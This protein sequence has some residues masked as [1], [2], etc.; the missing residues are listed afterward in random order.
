MTRYLIG[1]VLLILLGYGYMEALPLL[2][3]PTLA[4]ASPANNASFPGGIVDIQGV[5]GRA[6]LL[7]LD[8]MPLL[9]DQN[10]EFSSTLTFPSGGSILTFTV[11]DRFGRTVRVTR[12]IFVPTSNQSVN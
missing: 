12:S 1:T 4:I 11:T 8:G 5:A 6:A 10:G 9:H 3:G 7:T 2:T